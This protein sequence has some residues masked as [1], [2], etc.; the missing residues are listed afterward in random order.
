MGTGKEMNVAKKMGMIKERKV[1]K[2]TENAVGKGG[3]FL[4]LALYAFAG[5]GVEM[6]YAYLLEPLI[7]GGTIGMQDFSAWSD[8]QSILHWTIT[9]ITWGIIGYLLVKQSRDKYGFDLGRQQ[10]SMSVWQWCAVALCIVVAVFSSYLSWDG[11][12]VLLEFESKG[13]LLFTFQYIYYAF[14]TV[15]FMLIIVFAQKAFEVWFRN[16]RIPYG[17]IVCGLTWGLVHAVTKGSLFMGLEGFLL[18]FLLGTA[19]LFA[20]RDIKKTYVILFLMFVC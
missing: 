1:T 12:K 19:Y 6:L 9:C 10:E 11:F 13:A 5:L 17:G 8:G 20:G 2:E 18:G 7:Y 15:L 14:E 4:S 16:S 3:D